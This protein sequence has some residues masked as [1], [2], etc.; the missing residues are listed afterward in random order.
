MEK[1]KT[2]FI[3]L[4]VDGVLNDEATLMQDSDINPDHVKRLRQIVESTGAKIVL[5]SSWRIGFNDKME[6]RGP[7]SKTLFDA[8]KKENLT[9]FAKTV[10][11]RS[12]SRSEEIEVFL[13]ENKCDNFVILD[14][15]DWDFEWKTFL[16]HNFVHTTFKNGLTD[17]NVENAI[18]ILN[19]N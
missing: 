6:A 18:R 2:K 17:A 9:L 1:E 15:E 10:E 14:D 7:I 8:L 11:L 5:S 13:K 4:D 16:R 3:F 12:N 19:R